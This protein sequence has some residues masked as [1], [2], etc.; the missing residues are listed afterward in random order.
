VQLACAGQGTEHRAAGFD[1]A[2]C[3]GG[4][5]AYSYVLYVLSHTRQDQFKK[6]D[7]LQPAIAS[8]H[9]QA[10]EMQLSCWFI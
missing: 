2:F 7:H 8:L 6:D 1:A 9:R 5:K 10:S 3:E 4:M